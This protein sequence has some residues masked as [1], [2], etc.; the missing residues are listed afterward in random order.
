MKRRKNKNKIFIIIILVAS[1]FL[2]FSKIGLS[3]WSIAMDQPRHCSETP[4]A[5]NC[6]CDKGEIRDEGTW[7]IGS[8]ISFTIYSCYKP[9]NLL[10]D[11]NSPNFEEEA[12]EFA[13][14]YLD[15]YCGNICTDLSCGNLEPCDPATG[16][17]K[18]NS[19][20]CILAEITYTPEGHREVEVMCKKTK[21]K[22]VT[23][24]CNTSED[25]GFFEICDNGKCYQIKSSTISWQMKFY[26]TSSNGTPV[27]RYPSENYC[28]SPDGTEKCTP[29]IA[30]G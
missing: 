13:Q 20:G 2:I 22:F 14:Q 5:D 16:L 4:F 19:D 26:V 10:L 7:S 11:P 21:E 30:Q 12:I 24:S 8:D 25:C 17:P 9:E 27:S 6:Y 23:G 18:T 28:F 15:L 1:M 29:P 3:I